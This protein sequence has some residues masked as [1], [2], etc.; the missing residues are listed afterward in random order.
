MLNILKLFGI[1]VPARMAEL[2]ARLEQRVELAKDHVRQAAQTAAVVVAALLVLA[3][4]TVLSALGVGLIA[5]YRWVLLNYGQFYG[6]AAVGGVL[7][8][9]AIILLA[10][11]MLEAKSWSGE[12]AAEDAGKRLKRAEL[13]ARA[14]RVAE[15]AA[16]ALDRPAPPARASLRSRARADLSRRSGGAFVTDSV[17]GDNVS[18]D[19]E[20]GPR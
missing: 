7:I 17:E 19:G 18:H 8:L 13:Q 2:Q 6:L 11:A 1:D 14:D 20:S 16:A 3:G 5:L 12:G 9:I 4:L 15:Q 10:G